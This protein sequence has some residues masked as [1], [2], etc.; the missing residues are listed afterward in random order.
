MGIWGPSPGAESIA[1][2]YGE[3]VI[4]PKR[5]SGMNVKSV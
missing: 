4:N 5:T 2:C 3:N 1:G